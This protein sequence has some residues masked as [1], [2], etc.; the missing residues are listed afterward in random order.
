MREKQTRDG[1]AAL[2]AR[3]SRWRRLVT[4]TLSSFSS[5]RVAGTSDLWIASAAIAPSAAAAMA[6]CGPGTMSPAAK[7][8][9]TDVW[10]ASS[11]MMW[12][13]L[14][15]LAAELRAEVVGGILADGEEDLV[16]VELHAVLEVERVHA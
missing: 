13:P 11:T 15:A 8:L 4:S 9:R 2:V 12:P 1:H 6:S 14:V 10:Y 7:Q 16:G 5:F 3:A